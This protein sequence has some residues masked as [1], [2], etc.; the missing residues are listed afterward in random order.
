MIHTKGVKAY[1]ELD[2]ANRK[3][4]SPFYPETMR[5]AAR[6]SAMTGELFLGV[7]D[8]DGEP[9]FVS[10]VP[11]TDSGKLQKLLTRKEVVQDMVS[12]F[13]F[14]VYPGYQAGS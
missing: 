8:E 2:N 7:I 14:P 11:E 4:H 3:P 13:P 9:Y 12:R 1:F 6:K 10:T 5:E